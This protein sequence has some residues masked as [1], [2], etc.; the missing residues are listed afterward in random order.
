M[1]RKQG[2]VSVQLFNIEEDI[3][4]GNDLSEENPEIVND[5]LQEM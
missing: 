1:F 5:I 2:T 3:G 4:E